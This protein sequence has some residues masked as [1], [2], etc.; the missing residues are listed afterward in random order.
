[1]TIKVIALQ[2]KW[3]FIYPEQNVASVNF[4]QLPKDRPVNFEITADAPMNSFWIPQLGGQVYAMA[5]MSTKLHLMGNEIGNYKGS[6]A[7]LSGEGFA[8]MKFTARVGTEADFSEWVKEVKRS[9]AMLNAAT[10]SALAQP[11]KEA[12]PTYYA[13]TD[14]SLYDSVIMKYMMPKGTMPAMHHEQ[15]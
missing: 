7:N 15:E 13:T 9:P 3:L 14:P 2:W 12:L 4:V 1:M 5:G 6:S 8:D 10:Y 11:G